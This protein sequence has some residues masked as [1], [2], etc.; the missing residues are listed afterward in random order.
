MTEENIPPGITAVQS[1][2]VSDSLVS[3]RKVCIIDSGYDI[4][5]PDLQSTD[6]TGFQYNSTYPWDEDPDSHGT[7]VAGTIAAIGGNGIG[8]AGVV[9]NGGLQL[10]IVRVFGINGQS[11][12]WASGLVDSV[13][14]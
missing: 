5:H 10:Q 1:F 11:W 7:H 9:R 12:I 14:L 3:N 6:I 2:N 8:V 13:S 4:N